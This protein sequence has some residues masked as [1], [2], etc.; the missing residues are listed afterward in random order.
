M[1]S[2]HGDTLIVIIVL[3]AAVA[4]L[5]IFP[6]LIMA[7]NVEDS[8][9]AVLQSQLDHFTTEVASKKGLTEADISKLVETI[10]NPNTYNVTFTIQKVDENVGKKAVQVNSKVTG[11]SA[12]ITMFN[13]Q[14]MDAI[15][16][17][18][19]IDLNS[20]DSLTVTAEST[21]QS[22]AGQLSNQNPNIAEHTASS[23]KTVP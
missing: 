12:T 18:G 17:S 8:M 1:K 5:V 6:L 14:V 4:I 9:Q 22:T 10:S 13:S 11:E 20:G 21:N 7:D 19:K 2:E 16:T 23:T 15:H 3:L